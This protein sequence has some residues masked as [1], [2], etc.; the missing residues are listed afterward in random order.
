MLETQRNPVSKNQKTKK[1]R[2]WKP[3]PDYRCGRRKN[4]YIAH[5]DEARSVKEYCAYLLICAS[6]A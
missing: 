1:Q 3:K 6:V 5:G 2:C 4:K